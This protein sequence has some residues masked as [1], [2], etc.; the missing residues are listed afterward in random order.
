MFSE[1]LKDVNFRHKLIIVHPHVKE[2]GTKFD[3]KQDYIMY[4][5]AKL[6]ENE[7]V[8]KIL[9]ALRISNMRACCVI[10]LAR[11]IVSC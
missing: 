7:T 9:E 10:Q 1:V 8:P 6:G 5:K 2:I 11:Q 4:I 3:R